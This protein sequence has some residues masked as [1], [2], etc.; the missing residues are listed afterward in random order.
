MEIPEEFWRL[1]S[2]YVGMTIFSSVVWSL[3]TAPHILDDMLDRLYVTLEDHKNFELLQPIW[4]QHE[5]IY[6]NNS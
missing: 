1:Y 3:R 6:M 2:V 5:M 4:F